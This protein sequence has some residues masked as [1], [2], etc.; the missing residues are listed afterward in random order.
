MS[1]ILRGASRGTIYMKQSLPLLASQLCVCIAQ[2]E[3]DCREEV[4]LARPITPNNDI[5][6]WREGFDDCLV[7][8][9][10][11]PPVSASGA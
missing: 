6:L 5:V 3:S 11:V 7:F 8:V 9:T 10:V 1:D 4:T 2:N